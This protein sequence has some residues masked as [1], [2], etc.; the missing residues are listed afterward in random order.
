MQVQIPASPVDFTS[1]GASVRDL[2]KTPHHSWSKTDFYSRRKSELKLTA[3]S[4]QCSLTSVLAHLGLANIRQKARI[5]RPE[6]HKVFARLV[7]A[8]LAIHREAHHAGVLVVLAV[9]LPPAHRAQRQRGRRIERLVSTARAAEPV[10]HGSSTTAPSPALTAMPLAKRRRRRTG[11]VTGTPV[12]DIGCGRVLIRISRQDPSRF[13]RTIGCGCPLP[14]RSPPPCD[15]QNQ[16]TWTLGTWTDP[17]S[18]RRPPEAQL[19]ESGFGRTVLKSQ[20]QTR[21][22]PVATRIAGRLAWSV[23]VIDAGAPPQKRQKADFSTPAQAH[24][25]CRIR[26]GTA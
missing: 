9:I 8:Q 17:H 10:R 14:G 15:Q 23:D 12:R 24:R 6:P 18:Q 7:Q 26:N 13:P 25:K 3:R 11:R 16:V 21:P 4:S 2:H 20:R 1:H 19:W 22:P 5:A